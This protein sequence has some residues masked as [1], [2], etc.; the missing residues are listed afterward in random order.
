[1]SDDTEDISFVGGVNTLEHP[2]ALRKN[3]CVRTTNAFPNISGLLEKRPG[4]SPI[5]KLDIGPVVGD[6]VRPLFLYPIKQAL[7]YDFAVFFLNTSVGVTTQKLAL[8]DGGSI[9][10]VAGNAEVIPPCWVEYADSIYSVGGYIGLPEGFYKT[11]NILGVHT[12]EQATF[13]HV[14]GTDVPDTQTQSVPVLPRFAFVYKNRVR[15]CN[16]GPGMGH[17]MVSADWYKTNHTNIRTMPVSTVVGS[18]VLAVN[19]RHVEY[20]QI[21]GESIIAGCEIMLSA[22]G[23]P[24]QTAALLLTEKSAL[25]ITGDMTQTGDADADDPLLLIGSLEANKVNYEVGCCSP[26]TLV[27]T[28]Y[29]YIWS[30]GTDVWMLNQNAPVKI[31]TYISKTL[32]DYPEDGRKFWTAAYADNKYVLQCVI[33]KGEDDRYHQK[34]QWWL[35]LSNGMPEAFFKA[36][37]FGPMEVLR[38]GTDDTAGTHLSGICAD[39][40]GKRVVGTA[41]TRGF[42]VDPNFHIS[43]LVDYTSSSQID[44]V[45]FSTITGGMEWAP[46]T[47]YVV[48]DIV[49]PKFDY[50][51]GR[52]YV[53]EVAGISGANQPVWPQTDGGAVNDGTVPNVITW[54]EIQTL[55]ATIPVA[56]LL[57]TYAATESFNNSIDIVTKEFIFGYGP[58]DKVLK[59]VELYGYS[60]HLTTI[61]C[62]VIRN[63][64]AGKPYDFVY[65]IVG[66]GINQLMVGNSD[67]GTTPI[68]SGQL[69]GKSLRPFTNK[70]VRGKSMQF[71]FRDGFDGFDN[72]SNPNAGNFKSGGYVVDSSCNKIVFGAL[73]SGSSARLF[74]GTIT[75]GERGINYYA[76]IEELTAAVAV[77][78]NIALTNQL[79]MLGFTIASNPIAAN[80]PSA[81]AFPYFNGFELTFSTRAANN[82][83]ALFFGA[84]NEVSL[85]GSAVLG[86]PTTLFDFAKCRKLLAMM[87]FLTQESGNDLNTL[88]SGP[89]TV[90][91][92]LENSTVISTSP[93]SLYA[94]EMT[95]YTRTSKLTLANGIA[96]ARMTKAKPLSGN[97]R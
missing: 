11:S 50:N 67:L 51:T 17:W 82:L 92:V 30:S 59:R 8:A 78:M 71:R 54:R 56:R 72:F 7:G 29:G 84:S 41:L 93:T 9:I 38:D 60:S 86:N 87:G 14:D 83:F 26:H 62:N 42:S 32:S 64:G 76:N 18:D 75:L 94:S 95:Q 81:A 13:V 85:S 33:A 10:T 28:P 69:E 36:R 57:N 23:S 49:R 40:D 16:F 24:N 89:A 91:V 65:G 21:I 25:I 6:P 66:Q 37:W 80:T 88:L 46:N 74:Q 43:T 12:W 47:D 61:W 4:V 19:G 34:V 35:D 45:P 68:T 90:Y 52:M 55:I 96:F 3:Q 79:S 20:Q 58:L 27:K 15:Y 77:A 1:M 44:D 2:L 5:R 73:V 53:C 39:T 63:Q 31:G 97:N 48:G 70:I 22:V